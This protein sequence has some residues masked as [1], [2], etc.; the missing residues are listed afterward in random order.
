[1]TNEIKSPSKYKSKIDEIIQKEKE[2]E[3]NK[4]LVDIS[5]IGFNRMNNKDY[6][7][8]TILNSFN[9][10]AI[11]HSDLKRINE[12]YNKKIEILQNELKN[13]K[14]DEIPQPT[15]QDDD[16]KVS[17]TTS[18][19]ISE[20]K[21]IAV[22]T[23]TK[24]A[25]NELSKLKIDNEQITKRKT[26]LL[27]KGYTESEAKEIAELESIIDLSNKRISILEK[28]PDLKDQ[29][30]RLNSVQKALEETTTKLN[31]LL[32]IEN[33]AKNQIS[34]KQ[35]IRNAEEDIR[36]ISRDEKNIN[37]IKIALINQGYPESQAQEI[38]VLMDNISG[39]EKKK[40]I[41]I[42]N[43]GIQNGKKEL[44]KVEK[45]LEDNKSILEKLKILTVTPAP[46]I[47]DPKEK[48]NKLKNLKENLLGFFRRKEKQ[49]VEVYTKEEEEAW[50]LMIKSELEKGTNKEEIHN[51]ILKHNE[52]KRKLEVEKGPLSP[53]IK[54]KISKGIENWDNWGSEGGKSG[55]FKKTGKMVLSLGLIIGSSTISVEGMASLGIGTTSALGTGAAIKKLLIGLGFGTG[56][57]LLGTMSPEKA[58]KV[59]KVFKICMPSI[60]VGVALA[61]GGGALAAAAIGGSAAFGYIS[62]QLVQ[63]R[64]SENKIKAKFDNIKKREI[65][66]ATLKEDLAQIENETREILKQ[67]ENTRL[68][69]K[70]LGGA[71]AIGGSVVVLEASGYVH[72]LKTE[73]ITDAEKPTEETKDDENQGGTSK[74]DSI[75][76]KQNGEIKSDST[77]TKTSVSNTTGANKE[78]DTVT[79]QNEDAKIQT[80]STTEGDK[81][82]ESNQGQ[83]KF[84]EINTKF[85]SKGAIETIKELQ[86][87]IN[88]KYPDEMPENLQDFAKADP[89]QMA[90]KLGLYNPEDTTGS[91]SAMLI[92]GST[93]GFDENGN[94]SIHDFKTGED[95][96]LIEEKGSD[97]VIG[98]YE[99]KM[100]DSDH[101]SE[102]IEN[103][104]EVAG[105]AEANT[106]LSTNENLPRL[107]VDPET[108]LLIETNDGANSTDTNQNS[109]GDENTI[110][111][112]VSVTPE[113]KLT[114]DML[115]QVERTSEY[116]LDRIFPTDEAINQWYNIQ[117]MGATLITHMSVEDADEI[118]KPLVEYVHNLQKITGITDPREATMIKPAE[119]ISEYIDRA[120][121]KAAS[122]PKIGLDKVT[123]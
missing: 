111:K 108:G 87:E 62:S 29:D 100:F 42:N 64:F 90:I 37:E 102:N 19:N 117:T 11:K 56:M 8:Y 66:L 13:R 49:K 118:Y 36:K 71:V 103:N 7:G 6:S 52:E 63:K 97:D 28:F 73:Q 53:R 21:N 70:V 75:Q 115:E 120:L 98:K 30:K 12:E 31:S 86:T 47:E 9:G 55:F 121:E 18:G 119:S 82:S 69:R 84:E 81:S 17:T 2:E 33:V 50:M 109:G 4:H 114:P 35:K 85:S 32:K 14:G 92:K 96:I 58:K 59:G 41:L 74:N 51:L 24:K 65:N 57:S 43:P 15:T 39:D 20:P 112:E 5:S 105:Q 110:N 54:S 123:L 40:E 107:E 76:E 77:E 67:A 91:E 44:N 93:L 94:L 61:T 48:E 26:D 80:D 27:G 45:R 104:N 106:D 88:T 22:K 72:D 38:A 89:T 34:N 68:W 46:K 23:D 122:D 3:I 60:S 99:G 101:S 79:S 25:E 83:N 16:K 95:H 113:T 10:K 116:N 1:M 78:S